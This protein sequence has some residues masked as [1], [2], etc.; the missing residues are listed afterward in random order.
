[1]ITSGLTDIIDLKE[2]IIED[3]DQYSTDIEKDYKETASKDNLFYS[4]YKGDELL[5]YMG[6]IFYPSFIYCSYTKVYNR[7]CYKLMYK[8]FKEQYKIAT[9][10]NLPLLTDGT[11]FS[12]CKNHVT[13]FK[14]TKLFEWKL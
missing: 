4:W 5:G 6:F 8:Q 7:I 11:T 13:P 2:H 1:M 14:D 10:F 3:F 12:H 9:D